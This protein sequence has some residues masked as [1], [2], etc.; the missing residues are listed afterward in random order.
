MF[1][2]ITLTV[3]DKAKEDKIHADPDQVRQ[4]LLNCL[5][6]SAD[7]ISSAGRTDGAITLT[8]DLL[9]SR[10]VRLCIKD[11]GTGIAAEQLAFV[12]DPFYTTKEPGR[13]TGLGLSV[14]RSI[15][16]AAGGFMKLE[17]K[18]GEGSTVSICLPLAEGGGS[19]DG[20]PEA[21]SGN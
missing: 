1:K 17:S 12:F 21:G 7:A 13:G 3:Q 15:V 5:L 16:E 20:E 6:N 14:S 9:Q 8:S 19:N 4:V 11:N 2:H 18:A 10:Q